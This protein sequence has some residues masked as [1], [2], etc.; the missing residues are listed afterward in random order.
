MT[1]EGQRSVAELG[2]ILWHAMGGPREAP[3]LEA[4]MTPPHA[5]PIVALAIARRRLAELAVPEG[6]DRTFTFPGDRVWLVEIERAKGDTPA[7]IA[8]WRSSGTNGEWRKGVVGLGLSTGSVVVF[9]LLHGLESALCLLVRADG[10]HEPV[11]GR[12]RQAH[13]RADRAVPAGARRH[14]PGGVGG[15]PPRRGARPGRGGTGSRRRAE[16]L[17]HGS[18]D[19]PHR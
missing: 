13:A 15:E 3:E 19:R 5:D 6:V 12:G 16:A 11:A 18:D 4:W 8:V 7:G 10:D 1:H 17:R 2:A 9:S 14:R